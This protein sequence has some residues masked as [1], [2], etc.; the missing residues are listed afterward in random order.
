M[1]VH[2]HRLGVAGRLGLL[3]APAALVAPAGTLHLSHSFRPDWW[4]GHS[5]I[6]PV[7][8]KI[9]HH[10]VSIALENQSCTQYNLHLPICAFSQTLGES[11]Y[12]FK[13][14]FLLNLRISRKVNFLHLFIWQ[15]TLHV[16]Q[17]TVW[18]QQDCDGKVEHSLI[19]EKILW[20]WRE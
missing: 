8:L 1:G 5:Q 12:D 4:I 16:L 19:A 11:Y 3:A 18:D 7:K 13:Q 2:T 6:C 15:T 17:L 20:S 14:V 10:V 9:Q